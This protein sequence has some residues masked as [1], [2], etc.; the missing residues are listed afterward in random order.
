MGSDTTDTDGDGLTDCEEVNGLGYD[1]PSTVGVAIE[2]TSTDDPCDVL[3]SETG[4]EPVTLNA[5]WSTADCDGDGVTNG[6]E[7]LDGTDYFD[8]CSFIFISITTTVSSTA[9]CDGDGVSNSDEASDS[10][11]SQ[12]DC[13]FVS[14]SITLSIS[15]EADC[16]GD[17]VLNSNEISD[18]TDPFDDCSFLTSSISETI[19]ANVDCDGDAVSNAVEYSDGTDPFDECDFESE[20]VDLVNFSIERTTNCIESSNPLKVYNTINP[21]GDNLNDFLVIEGVE[22]TSYNHIEIFNRWGTKVFETEDYQEEANRFYGISDGDLTISDSEYLPAGTY[23]Y[24][25]KYT[26]DGVEY[27]QIGYLYI[28]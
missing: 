13:D 14:T 3:P 24:I 1:D 4:A 8:E 20:S 2:V 27:D 11:D 17:G 12:D 6:D 28:N 19:T 9:D 23:Y 5:I 7:Y 26:L 10:T 18:D 22:E 16:D 21:N 15:S 25:L